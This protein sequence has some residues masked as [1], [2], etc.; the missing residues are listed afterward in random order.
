MRQEIYDLL[1]SKKSK[2]S[3][4][5]SETA[6]VKKKPSTPTNNPQPIELKF[7]TQVSDQ[8]IDLF[9]ERDKD[10]SINDKV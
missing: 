10:D 4:E 6:I 1:F 7:S 3:I 8:K 2:K 5:K 9:E